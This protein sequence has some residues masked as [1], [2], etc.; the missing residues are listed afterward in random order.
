MP[1]TGSSG[2]HT[3]SL[4]IRLQADGF[5]FF[6]CD[7]HTNILVR[8]E[9]FSLAEGELLSD[10]LLLE[11]SRP[12]YSHRALSQAYVLLTG[13]S[14]CVPLEEFR[15][16][17][18]AAIYDFTL[19]R[20]PEH[21]RV[22]YTI[23]PQLECVELFA[24]DTDVEEVV[25]QYFPTARFFSSRAMLME[26]LML[27][28]ADAGGD[29]VRLYICPEDA[30]YS[31]FAYAD[32]RLRFANTFETAAEAD[33]LYFVLNVFQQLGLAAETD[34][35][36]MVAPRRERDQQLA[37]QLAGYVLH[38]DSLATTDLFPRV[39]LAAEPEVPVDLMALLLNR[40]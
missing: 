32:S 23:L 7:Q 12:D 14:T 33:A 20:S 9:H 17:E 21:H 30:G 24:V 16:D 35:V 3:Q 27:A 5:S 1:A 10:R 40:L 13:P 4:S 2:Y 26:R 11:L 19:G 25:L 28:D 31:I 37:K 15:R 22:A 29:H 36:V 18:A 34:H 39:R 8:G 6:V 38:V